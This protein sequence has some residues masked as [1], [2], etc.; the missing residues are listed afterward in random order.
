MEYHFRLPRGR[1]E[2]IPVLPIFAQAVPLQGRWVSVLPSNL[3]LL[4]HLCV[5]ASLVR[6]RLSSEPRRF[7]PKSKT[8]P[9]RLVQQ[10]AHPRRRRISPAG[11]I[12]DLTLDLALAPL[13]AHPPSPSAPP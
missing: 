11:N 8:M 6:D 12:L 2:N 4:I 9:E 13:D 7:Q 5:C 1:G 10:Q 3:L